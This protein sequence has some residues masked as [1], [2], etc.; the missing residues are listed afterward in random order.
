MYA[1]PID[2][3]SA[4]ALDDSAFVAA[5][6]AEFASGVDE[7]EA[8]E[9][10][11]WGCHYIDFDPFQVTSFTT[12]GGGIAYSATIN[13]DTN[14]AW[15]LAKDNLYIV[16]LKDQSIGKA[17]MPEEGISI[18]DVTQIGGRY[19][20]SC[21]NGKVWYYDMNTFEWSALITSAP[22]PERQ[23]RGET[24]TAADYVARTTPARKEHIFKYP[25]FYKAIAVGSDHYFLGALGRVVKIGAD[26]REEM[27]LDSGARLVT[28]SV[29]G[30]QAVLCGDSPIAEIFRGTLDSG[31]ERIFQNPE[32]ALHM[33][34][35]HKGL[36][37][38]G[39]AE[40]PGFFG[41]SLYTCE[42]DELTPVVTGCARE[43]D[44]L[45][46]LVSTGGVLWAID[47]RGIFRFTSDGWSLTDLSDIENA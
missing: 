40:Y 6:K 29:E 11:I 27:R 8:P 38:I 17:P 10:G 32:R 20:L 28:G 9:P 31:F 33:T 16:F 7:M 35:L 23:P 47:R 26:G 24:E 43:P 25:H 4:F 22:L 3:H 37:Y 34:A 21:S 12:P 41:P 45:L 46:Q 18:F 44:N 30:D 2:D 15:I 13:P 1:I 5:D 36:R 39:A 14:D 42:G 19:Y